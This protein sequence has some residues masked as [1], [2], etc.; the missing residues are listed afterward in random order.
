VDVKVVVRRD[1]HLYRATD[2]PSRGTAGF[3]WL[4]SPISAGDGVRY[5]WP[6]SALMN[7]SA[8]LS[9]WPRNHQCHQVRAAW[10]G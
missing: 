1:E 6:G 8:G 5:Q 3:L 4:P 7:A 9:V 10:L 2:L